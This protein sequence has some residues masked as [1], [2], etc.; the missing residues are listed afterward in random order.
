MGQPL[1]YVNGHN[2]RGESGPLATGWKGGRV[3]R[4][5]G[6]VLLSAHDHP[7]RGSYG[8]VLEHILVAEK[9]LGHLLPP[10][11]VVHHIDENRGN[12]AND[13]LVVC[14][15]REYHNQLHKRMRRLAANG[16]V[17]GFNTDGTPIPVLLTMTEAP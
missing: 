12:N 9:A 1:R 8:Y 3:T 6:Y 16:V 11:A 17:A 2:K 15:D 10:G 4:K 14:Q 13:N 7:R 5:D